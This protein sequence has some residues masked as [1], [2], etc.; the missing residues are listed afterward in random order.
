[1]RLRAVLALMM[2]SF[3]R[4]F[5]CVALL[6]CARFIQTSAECQTRNTPLVFNEEYANQVINETV[7]TNTL[8]ASQDLIAN[9]RY[10]QRRKGQPDSKYEMFRLPVEIPLAERGEGF[11]PFVIS[12]GALLK[13][14]SGTSTVDGPGESDFSL[15]RLF[16][17]TGGVGAYV[18]LWEEFFMV[19][20]LGLTYTHLRNNYDYNNPY[21][22]AVL[23]TLGGDF[24]NWNVDLLTCAPTVR[25]IYEGAIGSGTAKWVA[26]VSQLLNDS[27]H[28]TSDKIKVDSATGFLWNRLEY[29]KP[30]GVEVVEGE[31]AIRPFFQWSNI[32]GKAAAGLNLVNL[33]EVGADV[34]SLFKE[35]GAF[36]SDIY[37]G[38]SYVSGDSFEGYHLGLGGHF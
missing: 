1:V 9:G 25:F 30:L 20:S 5:V 12:S 4:L 6:L 37:V 16:S 15:S 33:Y 32:S 22:Q 7:N 31:L 3:R 27:I 17:V 29:K 28:A 11:R 14:T 36:F 23:Q 26:G 18:R 24:F 8:F 38:A 34:M 21:S 35:G 19:P 13:V 10:V 2:G